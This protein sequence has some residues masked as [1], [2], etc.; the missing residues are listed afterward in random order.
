MTKQLDIDGPVIY[1]AV[2][3]PLTLKDQI[4]KLAQH[5]D[6]SVNRTVVELIDLGFEHATPLP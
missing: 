3:M 1:M 4:V 2:R 6:Q 5:R